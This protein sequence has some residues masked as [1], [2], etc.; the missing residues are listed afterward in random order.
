[1]DYN[2]WKRRQNVMIKCDNFLIRKR[3]N[4]LLQN[5]LVCLQQYVSA[6]TKHKLFQK[7]VFQAIYKQISY[8]NKSNFYLRNKTSAQCEFVNHEEELSIVNETNRMAS[9]TKVPC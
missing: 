9:W 1:M 5:V 6:I 2:L 7:G 8:N 4:L 3:N